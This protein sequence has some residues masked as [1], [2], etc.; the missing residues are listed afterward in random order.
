MAKKPDLAA[1]FGA[2]D[3]STFLGL[4]RVSPA[5]K[6]S[7]SSAYIG[8]PGATPYGSVG[9]YC[10]NAPVVLRRAIASLTANIDRYN[11]DLDGPTFPDGTLPAVDCG[12]VVFDEADF[13]KNRS[14]ITQAVTDVLA[15]NA[16]P[17]VVGGDDSIPVPMLQA[18]A[19]TGKRYTI[20]QIDAHIDWRESHMGE[21]LGLSSTMRRASE[22][23][24]IEH[25]VQVGA[26]G[27]GSAHPQD[28]QDAVDSGV[29]FVTAGALHREGV[30]AAL[31]LISPGANIVVCLDVDALDPSIVPG[32]IGRTPGGLNYHQVL[33]LI[34]GASDKG[35]IS[36]IDF[37]EY[38]PDV[39]VDD[40][41]ALV[42]SRLIASTMGVLA[43]QAAR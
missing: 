43:R 11:F 19:S 31:D 22:M 10:H 26:R 4:R 9:A 17:I 38:M 24:H 23:S 33:D 32:V 36:A 40:L 30:T 21:T 25:I 28:Y 15:N 35:R 1:L 5:D 34:T 29:R 39:D 14:A 42:V 12:D 20:L 8:A 27:V 13:A 2:T 37:V 7:A 16:V 3:A 18:L 41:G 6:F